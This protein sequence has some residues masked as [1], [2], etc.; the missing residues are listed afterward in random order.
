MPDASFGNGGVV[1]T[2]FGSDIDDAYGIAIDLYGRVVVAGQTGQPNSDFAFA[3]LQGPPLTTVDIVGNDLVITDVFASGKFDK[4]K[5]SYVGGK[6]RI[7]DL[8]PL[9][10]TALIGMGDGSATVDVDPAMFSGKVIVNSQGG[11]DVLIVDPSFVLLGRNLDYNG[12]GGGNFLWV[13]GA[14]GGSTAVHSVTGPSPSGG[15]VL[16]DGTNTINLSSVGTVDLSGFGSVTTSM[17]ALA[18]NHVVIGQGSDTLSGTPVGMEIVSAA[19]NS[20]SHYFNNA[21]VSVDLSS[22]TGIN[23]FTVSGDPGLVSGNTNIT[24]KTSSVAGG[25]VTFASGMTL[26]GKLNIISPTV[27]LKALLSAAVLAGN[28]TTVNVAAPGSITQAI[29]ISAAAAAIN[30]APGTYSGTVDT[31]S[32]SITLSPGPTPGRVTIGGDLKLDADDTLSL[33]IN[34]GNP[35]SGYDNFSTNGS[36]SLGGAA[37]VLAGGYR[38][39]ENL[40]LITND[41]DDPIVGKFAGAYSVNGATVTVNGESMRLFY[42]HGGGNDVVLVDEQQPRVELASKAIPIAGSLPSVSAGGNIFYANAMSAD[43]RYL[44]YVSQATNLVGG[45]I[46]PHDPMNNSAN[47]YRYDRVTGTNV[48]VSASSDG[49]SYGNGDCAN[50]VVSADGN[51]VAFESIASN[52]DP[53]TTVGHENIFVRN[54]AMHTTY[55]ASINQSGTADGNSSSFRPVLSADGNVVAFSSF[56]SDLHP[57]DTNGPVQDVFARNLSTG[58]TYLV[59]I[60][61]DG[62]GSGNR[63]FS[64]TQDTGPNIALSADGHIVAFVSDATNLNALDTDSWP[65]IFARNLVTGITTL[66]SIN[67]NGNGGADSYL[68]DAPTISADGTAVA[69]ESTADNLYPLATDNSANIYARNLATNTTYLASINANGSA[70]GN[71]QSGSPVI[72]A[73]GHTVVFESIASDLYPLDT[74]GHKTDA[75]ARNVTTNT[76]YLVSTNNDGTGSGNGNVLGP[77]RRSSRASRIA[78]ATRTSSTGSAVSETRMVSPM[79]SAS[80]APMPTALFTVPD[81]AVPASVTPTCSG[82]SVRSERAR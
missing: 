28:A 70:S 29:T 77:R 81:Q 75:F 44:V 58:T 19:A 14:G 4:L 20:I 54:I 63:L 59:S 42:S 26:A 78:Q 30:A 17:P 31:S 1:T 15:T 82:A 32:K 3:R 65:D 55:L 37:L 61:K 68:T 50:P 41:L 76:T 2:D 34:G 79:P 33:Q 52:L 60:N 39:V 72:S 23:D 13:Q 45:F 24:L 11:N 7:Q 12:G 22:T 51:T 5:L 53:L 67:K 40:A 35:N 46:N 80:R 57:L 18:T 69:F 38:P 71:D 8:N 64:G 47:V 66:V 21:S 27:N 74:N 56:D 25:S 9:P 16:L 73:D 6:I 62:T 43:G 10:I 36:V 48:L 49:T